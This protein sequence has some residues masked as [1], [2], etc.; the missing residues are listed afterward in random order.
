MF[1]VHAVAARYQMLH[2]VENFSAFIV[3]TET[4]GKDLLG[5]K[6]VV[7]SNEI[8]RDHQNNGFGISFRI[9]VVQSVTGG[10][11]NLPTRYRVGLSVE[12]SL[13]FP[14]DYI[15]KFH[16]AVK[17]RHAVIV[18]SFPAGG[19]LV[20]VPRV[21]VKAFQIQPS[22]SAIFVTKMLSTDTTIRS[23]ITII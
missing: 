21:F 10:N 2:T 23:T 1:A 22:L 16:A 14:V 15:Y 3:R 18:C 9:V 8:E 19:I 11:E 6:L 4:A 20:A 5:K 12:K 17:M 13:Q 7:I